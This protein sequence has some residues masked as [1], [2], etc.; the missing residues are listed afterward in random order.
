MYLAFDMSNWGW[1][2]WVQFGLI[3]LVVVLSAFIHGHKRT[4]THSFPVQLVSSALALFI[5]TAGGFFA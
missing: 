3:V 2:Q 4:G 5:L 1:P